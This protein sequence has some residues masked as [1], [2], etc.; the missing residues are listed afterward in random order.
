M[1]GEPVIPCRCCGRPLVSQLTVDETIIAAKLAPTM[2]EILRILADAKGHWVSST[3]LVD[4]LYPK[5]GPVEA[6][7]A[8]RVHV[9]HMRKLL[10]I[11]EAA[12]EIGS[13]SNYGRRLIAV[14]ESQRGRNATGYRLVME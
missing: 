13:H 7:G 5:G 9:H 10:A 4:R 14:P 12:F 2:A 1:S 3:E 8:V 6:Q 11:A